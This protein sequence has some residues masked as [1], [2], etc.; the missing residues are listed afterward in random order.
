VLAEQRIEV[1]WQPRALG[2]VTI[3]PAWRC[4][5]CA[6]MLC[7]LLVPAATTI[8]CPLPHFVLRSDGA[9]LARTSLAIALNN[10]D[11]VQAYFE[12][13]LSAVDRPAKRVFPPSAQPASNRVPFRLHYELST[14]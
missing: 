8:C 12:G 4:H 2:G 6:S 5:H 1:A 10:A 3:C 9:R 13:K 11:S 14:S 7:W